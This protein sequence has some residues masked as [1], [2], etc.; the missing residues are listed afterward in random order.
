MIYLSAGHHLSD[1][2]AIANGYKE[3]QLC[4]ELRDLIKQELIQKGASFISDRDYETLIAYINRIKPG[5]GSV[6]CELHFNAS[7]NTRATGTE[8]LYATGIESQNL[9]KDLS[10]VIAELIGIPN[11]GAKDEAQSARGRLAVLRTKAGI[12]VLPEICFISNKLDMDAYQKNKNKVAKAIAS[13]LIH[14]DKLKS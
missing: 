3:S 9:A 10:Q 12:A 11:R 4:I 6:L 14:Y 5:S 8:V 2:G 1:P 13:Y 7:T